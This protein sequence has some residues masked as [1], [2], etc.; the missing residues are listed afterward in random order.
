MAACITVLNYVYVRSCVADIVCV[1]QHSCCNTNKTIIIII[2]QLLAVQT[3]TPH[4]ATGAQEPDVDPVT[5]WAA[6]NDAIH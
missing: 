1:I 4:W 2:S 3:V 5:S 6:S